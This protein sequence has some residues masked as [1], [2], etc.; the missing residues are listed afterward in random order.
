MRRRLILLSLAGV[1]LAGLLTLAARLSPAAPVRPVQV[2]VLAGQSNMVGN[3]T[4]ADYAL[5]DASL[6]EQ[7]A[8][9]YYNG[10]P[11]ICDR[12][13]AVWA[14]L[15]PLCSTYTPWSLGPELSFGASL[16]EAAPDAQLA[17]IKYALNDT[18]LKEEWLPGVQSTRC[19]PATAPGQPGSCYAGLVATVTD[20]VAALRLRYPGAP[21]EL[22]GVVWMQG[23][24]DADPSRAGAAESYGANLQQLI[25]ALRRDLQPLFATN[26]APAPPLFLYG[27][28]HRENFF[29]AA[30]QVRASQEAL[31]V[32]PGRPQRIV[33]VDTDSVEIG[34]DRLHYTANGQLQLGRLF[35]EAARAPS[36]R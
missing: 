3:L 17:L 7:P 21:I 32:A 35:A 6:R 26:T 18:S 5:L 8:V 9:A 4:Q 16:A 2:W 22:M 12:E 20:A 28:L 30:A 33:M 1:V 10:S 11:G 27:R 24:T 29:A 13:R 15:R 14:A 31:A 34:P 36:T 19:A 25:E 23:E